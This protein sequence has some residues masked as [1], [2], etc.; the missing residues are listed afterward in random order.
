M[1]GF[2]ETDTH[3]FA[4]YGPS[5]GSLEEDNGVRIFRGQS[6]SVDEET[7]KLQEEEYKMKQALALQAEYDEVSEQMDKLYPNGAGSAEAKTKYLAKRVE[8]IKQGAPSSDPKFQEELTRSLGQFQLSAQ[9]QALNVEK[10]ASRNAL[11][12]TYEDSK[13]GV[14]A[15]VFKAPGLADSLVPEIEDKISTV[16]KVAKWTPD[17][18][19]QET[20]Q[21]KRQ[22]YHTAISGLIKA[23]PDTASQLLRDGYYDAVL[24]GKEKEIFQQRIKDSRK[25]Q[26]DLLKAV[27]DPSEIIRKNQDISDSDVD[28]NKLA[29]VGKASPIDLAVIAQLRQK[30]RTRMSDKQYAQAKESLMDS[31]KVI[32]GADESDE[33]FRLDKL[34]TLYDTNKLQVNAQA[35]EQINR[36]TSER[37]TN[38]II[39][40]LQKSNYIAGDIN[41]TTIEQIDA[42]KQRIFQDEKAGR[43]DHNKALA[44][45]KILDTIRG[46]ISGR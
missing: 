16:G 21:V 17:E 44:E 46:H 26:D 11:I 22:L 32:L 1:V 43:L 33:R 38:R 34:R 41:K 30:E 5:Q 2:Y 29:E 25:F 6:P 10:V 36:E 3:E 23:D 27:Q 35:I 31:G 12:N 40:E 9:Q 8:Q 13:S 4:V 7:K 15:D 18:I 37:V 19:K 39:L 45:L 42:S 28:P 14:M 20:E 24:K